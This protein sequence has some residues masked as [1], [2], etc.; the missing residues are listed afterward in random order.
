MPRLEPKHPLPIRIFHWLNVPLLAVMIW[1]GLLIYS[2][3]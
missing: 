2:G 3:E 1:S